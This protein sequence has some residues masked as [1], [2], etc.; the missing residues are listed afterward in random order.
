MRLALSNSLLQ[1]AVLLVGVHVVVR[2]N[3]E[4]WLYV[5]GGDGINAARACCFSQVN[6]LTLVDF[7]QLNV[8]YY[9]VIRKV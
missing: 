2:V 8:F 3:F 4:F 9:I 1:I 7:K 6:C 5:F